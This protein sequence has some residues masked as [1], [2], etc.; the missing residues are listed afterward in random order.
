MNKIS[1]HFLYSG[2]GVVWGIPS[3][4]EHWK[5][6]GHSVGPSSLV[7]SAQSAR[8]TTAKYEIVSC[9]TPQFLCTDMIPWLMASNFIQ[10]W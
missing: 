2:M 7:Q 5:W 10:C 4:D 1:F 8:N 3:T 6:A 9:K